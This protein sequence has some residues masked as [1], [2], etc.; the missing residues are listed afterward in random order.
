MKGYYATGGLMCRLAKRSEKDSVPVQIVKNAG[1][2]PLCRGNAPQLLMLAETVNQ[3][4]GRTRN[5]WNWDRGVGGSSGGDAALV[6]MKCVP[7]AL[8]SDVAGSCRI[9]ACCCGV[10]GF[11]PTSTRLSYKG[12]MK[13]KK[14]CLIA[15][16]F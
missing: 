6:A 1:A 9:P 11:K 14:V 3:I 7:M 15:V 13:P 5:P 8:C 16:G 2:I 4:W 12:C 10:V